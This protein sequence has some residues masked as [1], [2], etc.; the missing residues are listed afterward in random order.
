M[1]V[2][3]CSSTSYKTTV[4]NA[5]SKQLNGNKAKHSR[6]TGGGALFDL[7]IYGTWAIEVLKVKNEGA[8]DASDS[9]EVNEITTQ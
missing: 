5:V 1:R 6:R 4:A 7:I 8:N 9:G 2:V 3:R